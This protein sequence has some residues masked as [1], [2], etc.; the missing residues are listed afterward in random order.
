MNLENIITNNKL[1][2]LQTEY[3]KSLTYNCN[4][5]VNYSCLNFIIECNEGQFGGRLVIEEHIDN[6]ST[7]L[8]LEN[9]CMEIDISDESMEFILKEI[10]EIVNVIKSSILDRMEYIGN[11]KEILIDSIILNEYKSSNT[12]EEDDIENR[13]KDLYYKIAPNELV[14]SNYSNNLIL[15]TK[16]GE[17][18]AK[19]LKKLKIADY[20]RKKSGYEI[21]F[22]D[23]KAMFS[24]E[25]KDIFAK[26]LSKLGI[27][28]R[29]SVV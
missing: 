8:I 10:S 22:Y 27:S 9:I 17:Y 23:E 3:I 14:Y 6:I 29:K 15:F 19:L 12:L 28:D 2:N 11:S 25:F 7:E 21:N 18:V 4:N 5:S 16:N 1:E 24:N 26:E 13:V 20:I